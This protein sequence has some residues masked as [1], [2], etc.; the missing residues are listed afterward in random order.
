MYIYKYTGRQLPDVG[1][2]MQY[3]LTLSNNFLLYV[4]ST[5]IFF[6]Y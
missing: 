6:N 3:I 2:P 5:H 4:L 1:P